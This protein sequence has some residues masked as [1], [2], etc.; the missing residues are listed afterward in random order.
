MNREVK[1]RIQT[2]RECSI[3]VPLVE[4]S[5]PFSFGLEKTQR[6]GESLLK[7]FCIH[8]FL[9]VA[10]DEPYKVPVTYFLGNFIKIFQQL[11]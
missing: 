8:M 2:V 5:W 10:Q 3:T 1:S 7:N 4:G 11:V 6:R 9:T